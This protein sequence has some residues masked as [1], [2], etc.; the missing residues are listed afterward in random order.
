M[1]FFKY[2]APSLPSASYERSTKERLHHTFQG[3]CTLHF[4]ITVIYMR[5]GEES[6][7]F[8]IHTS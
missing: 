6:F 2:I 4:K 3:N 8:L 7:H 5:M 1:P